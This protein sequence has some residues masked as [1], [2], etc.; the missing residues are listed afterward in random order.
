VLEAVHAA[1]TEPP[2][3]SWYAAEMRDR[4]AGARAWE[5]GQRNPTIAAEI[6]RFEKAA[7]QRLGEAGVI[8]LLRNAQEGRLSLPGI[9]KLGKG[10]H[11]VNWRAASPRHGRVASII[12]RSAPKTQ[13]SSANTSSSAT[14]TGTDRAWG[15]RFSMRANDDK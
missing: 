1:R 5:M 3:D 8:A 7:E 11:Y 2:G 14:G 10:G 12:N 4:P 9:S 15:G 13:P 6:D